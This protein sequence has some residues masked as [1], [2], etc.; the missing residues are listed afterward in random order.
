M[1]PLLPL[2][3]CLL[4]APLWA[5]FTGGR[6]A[7]D[8]FLAGSGYYARVTPEGKTVQTWRGGNNNDGWLL[9]N[10]H[11]LAADGSAW[12]AAPSRKRPASRRQNR[13]SCPAGDH[14]Q[15]SPVCRAPTCQSGRS[16]TCKYAW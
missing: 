10:G 16:S 3:A 14:A 2:L 15:A 5:Q 6:P 13:L 8:L 11:I 12:E 4:A 9:P 7:H 1:K